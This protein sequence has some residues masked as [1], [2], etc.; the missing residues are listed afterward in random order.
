MVRALS[1]RECPQPS[2]FSHPDL[3]PYRVTARIKKAP[4]QDRGFLSYRQHLCRRFRFHAI[5]AFVATF[6]TARLG[7]CGH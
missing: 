1:K 2:G 4:V 6:A 5:A 7:D 3:C